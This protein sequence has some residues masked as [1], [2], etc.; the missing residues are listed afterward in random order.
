MAM[1]PIAQ[2]KL[3]Q[4][5][6]TPVPEKKSGMPP[7]AQF[8]LPSQPSQAPQA[9]KAGGP[10]GS[11]FSGFAKEVG[12]QV[13]S[14]A[15]DGESLANQ[16]AGRVVNKVLGN[17]FTPLTPEQQGDSPS[18]AG[19]PLAQKTDNALAA[20]DNYE[21]AG[22]VAA[23][24]AS[25]LIP[26]KLGADIVESRRL[27]NVGRDALNIA[28][29][30]ATQKVGEGLIKLG[31][32]AKRVVNGAKA[33]E[34]M[35]RD[36]VLKVGDDAK[37]AVA[38]GSALNA[39]IVKSAESL[40][41][42]LRS[43]PVTKIATPQHLEALLKKAQAEASDSM[44]NIP[45]RTKQVFDKFVSFLPKGKDITAE[46]ILQA[47]KDTDAWLALDRGEKALDA[48]TH[49][50]ASNSIQAIRHAAND[51]IKKLAPGQGVKKALKYQSALYK[52]LE[53]VSAK[54][55]KAVNEAERLA[56][57]PGIKGVMARHPHLTRAAE[58]AGGSALGLVGLKKAQDFL[59]Q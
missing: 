41:E 1:P 2:F 50:A 59:G 51:L 15:R 43:M 5:G 3:P 44:H 19:S 47:R 38:N 26:G 20:T 58:I 54:G 55:A 11:L 24:G 10:I 56:N 9:P 31:G 46:D 13:V 34:H 23:F 25:M 8:A 53:N 18:V 48:A 33:I 40:V 36:K 28:G 30:K 52:V 42:R 35:V 39:E 7:V 6:D 17:G 22:K 4:Q 16:T 57:M 45:E 12:S 32:P 27:A 29:E 49:N 14:A 37:T 21:R